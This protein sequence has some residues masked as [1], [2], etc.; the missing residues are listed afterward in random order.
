[1]AVGVVRGS[2]GGGA[3]SLWNGTSWSSEP[4]VKRN[5]YLHSVTCVTTTVCVAVGD[6]EIKPKQEVP[7]T[8][9]LVTLFNGKRWT[10]VTKKIS[11]KRN[12]WDSLGGV[13]CINAAD[14]L[15]VGEAN[16]ALATTGPS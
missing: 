7:P 12:R 4:V 6:Y 16:G 15:A 2:H 11:P 10:I 1:M 14:C 9:S 3:F 8:R 5:G 13:A